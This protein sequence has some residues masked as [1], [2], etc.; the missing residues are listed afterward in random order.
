MAQAAM[1]VTR[2]LKN[3]LREVS[4]ADAKAIYREAYD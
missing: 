3:N 2:L 1:K 4:E